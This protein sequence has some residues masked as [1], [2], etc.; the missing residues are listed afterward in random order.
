M[1][2]HDEGLIIG[3]RRHGETSVILEVMTAAHG[4]HLGLV[5]GGRSRRMRPMLQPG[6]QASLTWR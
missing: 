5:R 4:R 2:W 6:N 1:E 3:I